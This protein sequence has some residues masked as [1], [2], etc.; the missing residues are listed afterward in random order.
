[1][2]ILDQL[3]FFFHF[4]LCNFL[5]GVII[6]CVVFISYI[7]LK[8]KRKTTATATKNCWWIAN[9]YTN[10]LF[11]SSYF[12]SFG[13]FFH[14]W[15]C[16]LEGFRCG[17]AGWPWVAWPPSLSNSSGVAPA[18]LPERHV[19]HQLLL[20]PPSPL[21]SAAAAP[22]TVPKYGNGFVTASEKKKRKK[23]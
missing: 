12:V 11:F 23:S 17:Q 16:Y 3:F 21:P 6:W 14:D 19:G 4:M 8:K 5:V 10:D 22:D 7:H 9:F 20:Q 2:D 13:F 1:M 18:A 15:Y